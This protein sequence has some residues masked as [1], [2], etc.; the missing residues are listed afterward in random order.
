MGICTECLLNRTLD[1]WRCL[2]L[3]SCPEAPRSCPRKQLRTGEGRGAI[4]SW[5]GVWA[6]PA[7]W[8]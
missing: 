6:E 5:K 3:G 1:L 2:G 4:T 7:L 8:M